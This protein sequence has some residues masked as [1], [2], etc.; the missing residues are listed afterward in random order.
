MR[1]LTDVSVSWFRWL[2]ERT[3][4]DSSNSPARYGNSVGLALVGRPLDRSSTSYDVCCIRSLAFPERLVM[5]LLRKHDYNTCLRY[6]GQVL[7]VLALVLNANSFQLPALPVS[8]PDY[9]IVRIYLR[10]SSVL[11]P[12]VQRALRERAFADRT[13]PSLVASGLLQR[14][15]VR[16][17]K[18]HSDFRCASVGEYFVLQRFS[19]CVAIVGLSNFK[20]N[21]FSRHFDSLILF[22]ECT[23]C[24]G[25][26]AEHSCRCDSLLVIL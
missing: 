26:A 1:R 20:L 23:A 15:I 12:P 2:Y 4:V 6:D 14:T 24:L 10:Y 19:S 22:S 5:C 7:C 18:Y 21:I 8:S 11:E 9:A 16:L 3:T 13:S 25:G 17:E